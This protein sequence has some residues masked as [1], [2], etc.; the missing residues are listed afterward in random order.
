M[1]TALV[2][3]EHDTGNI[4]DCGEPLE[5]EVSSRDLP[6]EGVLLEKGW[7]PYFIPKNIA[8]PYFYFALALESNFHWTAEQRGETVDLKT[9]PGEIWMNPPDV[10]FTHVINEPCYFIILAINKEALFKHYDGAL[11]EDRLRFLKNYNVNDQNLE[12]YIRLFYNEVCLQG[13]NGIQY[14]QSLMRLFSLYYIKNYSNHNDLVSS[15]IMS[16]ITSADIEKIT[17]H[18]NAH[19]ET[20]IAIEA[21]ADICNYSKYYF[22]KEFKKFTGLTPYQYVLKIKLER[23]KEWLR[24]KDVQIVDIAYRLGFSDQSHFSNAFKKH[25]GYPPGIIKSSE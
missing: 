8:T 6:W 5:I 12:Y 2:Y 13:K 18:V 24:D 9:N 16:R 21:L 3:I 10:P 25:F 11:P 17:R 14:F 7:S 15:K 20:T 19:I 1:R 4:S 22:L 23:A